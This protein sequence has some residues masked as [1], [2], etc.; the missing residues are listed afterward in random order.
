MISGEME[1][2]S[3]SKSK[4]VQ[5]R[6]QQEFK[7]TQSFLETTQPTIIAIYSRRLLQFLQFC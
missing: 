3:N 4:I 1:A 7:F 6:S 2:I 5:E